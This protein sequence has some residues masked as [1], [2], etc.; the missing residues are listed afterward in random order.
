MPITT[1]TNLF[2]GICHP[3][4]LKI[5]LYKRALMGI[6][7]KITKTLY[8]KHTFIHIII[9][10]LMY[11]IYSATMGIQKHHISIIILASPYIYVII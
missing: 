4:H 11:P 5:G 2:L 3:I 7:F 9:K 8:L 6:I 1:T 10:T